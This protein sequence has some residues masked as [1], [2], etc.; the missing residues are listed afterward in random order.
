[1]TSAGTRSA[2]ISFNFLHRA[3][4]TI[5]E[6]TMKTRLLTLVASLGLAW[7]ATTSHADENAPIKVGVVT[8]L[9]GP[10]AGPFGVPARNA[11]EITAELLNAGKA[12]APM[13]KRVS[14]VHRSSWYLSTK[15]AV[16]QPR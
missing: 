3:H 4:E 10:A 12:P 7:T 8:F 6:S 5:L 16:Q 1:V 11:A 14:A 9:S 2:S 13:R 15:Q